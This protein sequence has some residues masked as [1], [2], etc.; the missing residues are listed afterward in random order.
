MRYSVQ[1]ELILNY[2]R[3]SCDHPT[4]EN[5]YNDLRK[6][7]PNISLGTIYRN[8]NDL[9]SNNLIKRIKV[10]GG[11]DRFDKTVSDHYHITCLECG[12]VFDIFDTLDENIRNIEK[13]TGYTIVSHNLYY[14]GIC[15][16]CR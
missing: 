5:I 14:N 15:D 2:V 4:A 10:P 8:L 16:Q 1:R 9:V 6:E 13:Q 12:K 7:L 11:N 3:N